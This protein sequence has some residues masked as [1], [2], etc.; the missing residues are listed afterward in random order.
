MNQMNSTVLK[1]L[2][3]R[4][5]RFIKYGTT[6]KPLDGVTFAESEFL[7]WLR[8]FPI[9]L[10]TL[11]GLAFFLYGLPWLTWT[12]FDIPEG[13]HNA[14]YAFYLIILFGIII[15]SLYLK[16]NINTKD[17]LIDDLRLELAQ[18]QVDADFHG[19]IAAFK[20]RRRLPLQSSDFDLI[21]LG[22]SILNELIV[23]ESDPL[24]KRSLNRIYKSFKHLPWVTEDT[25]VE[26]SV[27]NCGF[28]LR[29]SSLQI[30]SEGYSLEAHAG[31]KRHEDGNADDWI[32]EMQVAVV[33]N[34][35]SVVDESDH[36]KT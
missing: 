35:V 7:S 1:D 20:P 26:V 34:A 29:G 32:V 33:R 17:R 2:W 6:E 18:K 14:F 11:V 12:G 31:G 36:G 25:F 19:P 13:K 10:L 23:K 4:A 24:R 3:Q 16:T 27:G 21:G 8:N 28:A 15:F 5:I 22:N 9:Y 30:F